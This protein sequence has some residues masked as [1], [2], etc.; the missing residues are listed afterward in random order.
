MGGRPARLEQELIGLT[1]AA[2]RHAVAARRLAVFFQV[3]ASG[4]G[5]T[6]I[7]RNRGK[8]MA[9]RHALRNFRRWPDEAVFWSR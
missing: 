7:S 8:I 9:D 6:S 1:F 2:N 4:G 5:P 3:R